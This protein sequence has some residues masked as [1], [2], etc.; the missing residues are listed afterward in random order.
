MSIGKV[1]MLIVFSDCKEPLTLKIDG[2]ADELSIIGSC[3]RL[4]VDASFDKLLCNSMPVMTTVPCTVD[5]M[6]HSAGD[7]V[8]LGANV[9]ETLRVRGGVIEDNTLIRAERL[10]L[11]GAIVREGL[12]RASLV[13]VSNCVICTKFID[14]CVARS[15]SIFNCNVTP[16]F[17]DGIFFGRDEVNVQCNVEDVPLCFNWGPSLGGAM[18]YYGRTRTLPRCPVA[19]GE[20]VKTVMRRGR[21]VVMHEGVS[22]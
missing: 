1:S 18:H 11:R 9:Y 10:F 16:E 15:L 14:E 5:V 20:I 17:V 2:S 22:G 13:S 19:A 21:R 4:E 8:E 12:V 7:L 6:P 3:A